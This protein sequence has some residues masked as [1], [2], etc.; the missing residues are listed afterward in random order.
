MT[1]TLTTARADLLSLL[2][3]DT[4]LYPA[5][6]LDEA[7]RQALVDLSL[8]GPRKTVILTVPSPSTTLSLAALPDLLSLTT[9]AYPYIEGL[10]WRTAKHAFWAM[11]D[12]TTLQLQDGQ[13]FA[14]GEKALLIYQ[15]THTLDGLDGATAATVPDNWK[16][17]LL[18]AAAAHAT[19]IR[20]RQLAESPRA[21][22]TDAFQTLKH[23][24]AHYTTH[25]TRRIAAITQRMNPSW[26]TIGL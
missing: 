11:I 3:N 9:V 18:T 21:H 20:L 4:S 19:A 25:Y 8:D 17:T 15:R 10:D 12:P 6:T 2:G 5:A 23:L 22:E 16:P 13:W 14:A 7:L 24:H 1:I 26:E